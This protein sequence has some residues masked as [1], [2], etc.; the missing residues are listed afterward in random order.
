MR[1]PSRRK[2]RPDAKRV[3][4]AL[5]I[6]AVDFRLGL[7]CAARPPLIPPVLKIASW[8]INSVRL[9]APHVAR[10]VSEQKIDVLCLQETKCRD[11]EFPVKAFS[12]MGLRHIHRVGQK[13]Y[14]G[15]AFASKHK[16]S[17]VEL[18][19]CPKSEARAAAVNIN[20]VEIHNIYVPAG[21]DIPDPVTNPKFQHKLDFVDA[22]RA[23]YAARKG[24][25]P[26]VIVGDLNIAPGE[27]DVWSHK[28]LLDV[29]SHTPA[30]TE[31]LDA[32]RDDGGFVDLARLHR[33]APEKLF[34]WWSYRSPDYTVNNRGRRLDHIWAS[35][36]VATRSRAEGFRIHQDCRSWDRPSDHVPVVAELA[37]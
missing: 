8:N 28:Q 21:A 17:P 5:L 4:A 27:H 34:T 22:M 33:P 31:R 35:A 25:K 29:V 23:Y 7:A 37:I 9:R 36:D 6:L 26:T 19:L 1:H 12:A 32:V 30:E 20:G 13:G 14:H 3:R 10:F 15:V 11:E 16:M 18:R 2:G 24:K